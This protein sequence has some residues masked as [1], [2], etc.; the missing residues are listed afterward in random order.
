MGGRAVQMG[1]R[2]CCGKCCEVVLGSATYFTKML[3]YLADHN[4]LYAL[5]PFPSFFGIPVFVTFALLLLTIF[6][7]HPAEAPLRT[8]R[9]LSKLYRQLAGPRWIEI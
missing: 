1:N 5:L 9:T 7:L 8:R 6:V 4:P 2:T 3:S